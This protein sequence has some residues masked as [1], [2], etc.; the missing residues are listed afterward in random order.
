MTGMGYVLEQVFNYLVVIAS[1]AF[2]TLF[3]W[4]GEKIHFTSL[5]A[6]TKFVMLSVFYVTYINYGL[7]YLF[8]SLDIRSSKIPLIEHLFNGLYPEFNAL[9]YNDIGVL[10]IAIM[11]SNMYWPVLEFFLFYGIR[12]LYRMIDQRTLLPLNPLNTNCKSI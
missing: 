6:E 4:I 5:T 1:F 2:R 8:A 7:I 12:L 3:I 11:I 9:W 10:I